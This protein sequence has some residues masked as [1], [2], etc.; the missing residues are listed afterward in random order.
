MDKMTSPIRIKYEGQY[1]CLPGTVLSSVEVDRA[2]SMCLHPTQEQAYSRVRAILKQ[3]LAEVEGKMSKYQLSEEIG[4][5]IDGK[6]FSVEQRRLDD[7]CK[8]MLAACET[9]T[10]PELWYFK[11]VAE[12]LKKLISLD[13]G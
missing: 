4:R 2:F 9:S 7:M 1:D 3:H 13:R 11:P 6:E 5:D 12:A 10:H 8:H